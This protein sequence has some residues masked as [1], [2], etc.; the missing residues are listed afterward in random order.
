MGN[1]FYFIGI[2]YSG[3]DDLTKH[4]SS[5]SLSDKEGTGLRL[6]KEQAANDFTI[7]AKFFTKRALNI[8]AI[9]RTF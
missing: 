8:D 6:K 2:V 5:L 1:T 3:M 9:A 4:W 7:A